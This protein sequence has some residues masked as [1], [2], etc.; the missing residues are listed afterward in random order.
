MTEQNEQDGLEEIVLLFD[1]DGAV[2]AE[3]RFA[4]FEALVNQA[5]P[6][7]EHAASVVEAVYA[8]VATGLAVRGLVFF[9]F[10]VNE[11]G[12]LDPSFNVPLRYLVRNAGAGPDL[13]QGPV[14]LACRGQCPVPWHAT[15]LWQPEGE[16]DAHPSMRTQKAV[17]RNRLGLKPMASRPIQDDVMSSTITEE[18]LVLEERLTHTFGEE[19]KVSLQQLIA[20]HNQQLSEV[21]QRYRADLQQQQRGYLDQI[22]DCRDEMQKLKATLRNEQE[23]SR[24]R[25]EF[26]GG[27]GEA[28]NQTQV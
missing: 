2:S 15:N 1:A 19:G 5:A 13:G 24:R 25:H 23:R 17:W 26:V 12:F 10:S 11:D 3:M 7:D 6:L 16:G 14:R 21:G 27:G 8:V 20:Q 22:R 9:T 4:E 28:G 18:H